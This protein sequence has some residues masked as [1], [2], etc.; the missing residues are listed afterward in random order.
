MCV[1]GCGGCRSALKIGHAKLGKAISDIPQWADALGVSETACRIWNLSTFIW[2]LM[3]RC[4]CTGMTPR[5]AIVRASDRCRC[6]VKR[7][8]KLMGRIHWRCIRHCNESAPNGQSA[9]GDVRQ[10]AEGQLRVA[11]HADVLAIVRNVTEYRDA[12]KAG[13]L[14]LA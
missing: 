13:K 3:F 10:F 12:R 4:V 1:L 8:F 9:A 11:A 6:S 14:A 5:C 2:T 7:I